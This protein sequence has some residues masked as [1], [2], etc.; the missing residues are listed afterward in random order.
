MSLFPQGGGLLTRLPGDWH[1]AG[2]SLVKLASS[3]CVMAAVGIWAMPS[4]RL[5]WFAGT[6]SQRARPADVHGRLLRNNA[7]RA[8]GYVT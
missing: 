4:C 3:P 2:G 6:I 5:R 1:V 7:I 8:Y